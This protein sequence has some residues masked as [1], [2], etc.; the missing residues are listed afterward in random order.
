MSKPGSAGQLA[1]RI[2]AGIETLGQQPGQHPIERYVSFLQLLGQWNKAYNLTAVRDPEKM[3]T[4]LVLDSL[5]VL[6]YVRGDHGLDVGTGAGLPGLILALARPDMRW[7]LLDSRRKKI[8]FI[9]Q[10][11]MELRVTNVET[12]CARAE[13]YRTDALFSTVITRAFGSLHKFY[14]NS[15]HLVAPAGVLLA[16]KG[17]DMAGEIEELKGSKDAPG[18][19]Q[20]HKLDVPGFEKERCLVE[21]RPPVR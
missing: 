10:A 8:R 12:V 14:A 7:V 4:F 13:E 1:D 6:P 21:M 20:V 17:G 18:F 16:M 9:T 11:I 15:K 2:N 3:V 19:I 5:A